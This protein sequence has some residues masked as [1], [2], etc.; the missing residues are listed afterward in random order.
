MAGSGLSDASVAGTST[1]GGTAAGNGAAP[2]SANGGVSLAVGSAK[3]GSDG[4]TAVRELGALSVGP[5]VRSVI[6]L[7]DDT[8][9]HAVQT[10][11]F[12]LDARKADGGPLP[13]WVAFDASS[14]SFTVDS[15]PSGTSSIEVVVTARDRQ[16]HVASTQLTLTVGH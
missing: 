10:G 1:S 11:G 5:D 16:G 3:G 13:A 9:Q 6:K 15:P 8:F 12:Q 14:G 2:G 4:F 7:P